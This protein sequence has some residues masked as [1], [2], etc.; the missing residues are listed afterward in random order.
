[1]LVLPAWLPAQGESANEPG[2]GTGFVLGANMLIGGTTA[3]V[4]AM[5]AK[6]NPA[7]AFAVGAV[8]GAVHVAGKRFVAQRGAA[9]NVAGFGLASIGSAVVANAGSGVN[10]LAE[11]FVPLG[12]LRARVHLARRPRVSVTVNLYEAAVAVQGFARPGLAIDWSRSASA[13]AFVF[14][15]D[16]RYIVSRG[17][18][19]DGAATGSVVVL[20]AFAGDAGHTLRHEAVHVHQHWFMQETWGRPAERWLRSSLP[21]MKRLPR[22]MEL[23]LVPP[24]YNAVEVGTMGRRAPLFNGRESEAL[25]LARP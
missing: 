8:G 18:T 4:H 1:M 15:T 23:G 22:W 7:R 11:L 2:R 13:G 21:G 9:S 25:S 17:D 12:P 5:L 10:P 24:L 6:R 3:A 14:V 19:A 16:D 20:S